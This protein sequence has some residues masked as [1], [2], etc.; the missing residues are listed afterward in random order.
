MTRYIQ[1]WNHAGSYE[2]LH[3]TADSERQRQMIGVGRMGIFSGYLCRPHTNS[4]LPFMR[5]I[6][7][8]GEESGNGVFVT[9]GRDWEEQAPS[10]H[11]RKCKR[12][13]SAYRKIRA[14]EAA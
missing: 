10:I 4:G 3:A 5:V 13:D 6:K 2:L 7:P 9:E 12:C 1:A 11:Q 14:E 8:V